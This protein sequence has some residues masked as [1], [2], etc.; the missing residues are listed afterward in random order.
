MF[1]N[2]ESEL[3]EVLGSKDYRLVRK[4]GRGETAECFLVFS[5]K[6]KSNF[7]CKRI[8][9]NSGT[10][11]RLCEV[12][13]LQKLNSHF[14]IAFYDYVLLANSIYIFLEFCP[15]GTMAEY[16]KNHGPLKDKQLLG[17]CKNILESIQ[18][19]HENHCAHLDLKPSNIFLDRYGRPKV[20]D[21]GL[22]RLFNRKDVKAH[23]DHSQKTNG[24]LMFMA[25]ELFTPEIVCDPFIADI[26]SLG[27]AFY[28]LAVGKS[29]WTGTTKAEV[30]SQISDADFSWPF[31]F[32]NHEFVQLVNQMC[33]LDP[34]DRPTAESLL[35]NPIFSKVDKK[36]GF[37]KI[38]K[39]KPG[40]KRRSLPRQERI[41]L[42]E[43]TLTTSAPASLVAYTNQQSSASKAAAKSLF[44]S[45]VRMKRK[46]MAMPKSFQV[47][48]Y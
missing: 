6:Y 8:K 22:A 24:T 25:P 10:V 45:S 38:P 20:A 12:E 5:N 21:F 13:T 16:I 4:I 29:P 39:T 46:A 28:F 40:S 32:K 47:K 30:L 31:N 15:N 17:V 35:S 3:I 44:Q 26:W 14:V 48:H 7:V 34:R 37:L 1:A 36:D 41:V 9:F 18:Y 11:C 19:I 42:L 23:N 27:I 2:D 43:R 33:E